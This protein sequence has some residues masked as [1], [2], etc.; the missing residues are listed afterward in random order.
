MDTSPKQII[1]RLEN[2]CGLRLAEA[3]AMPNLDREI[4][5][6]TKYARQNGIH[7]SPTF[8]I[9]GLVQADMSSGDKVSDWVSQLS[10]N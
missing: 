2:Y 9:D 7:V 6:H 4:K 10:A 5:W 1:A 3:F 8:M